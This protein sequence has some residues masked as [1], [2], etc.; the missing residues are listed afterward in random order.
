M[1]V[2]PFAPLDQSSYREI[3]RRALAE[4]VRWG[5]VTTEAVVSSEV[6]AT[7]VIVVNTPCVLAGL[8]VATECFRQ[9]DPHVVVDGARRE[10]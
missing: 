9:L 2:T 7:G 5:D 10:G 3:V 4:D 8:D 6:R 1:T